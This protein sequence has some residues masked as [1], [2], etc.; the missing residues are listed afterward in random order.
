MRDALVTRDG[1]AAVKRRTD[2][3]NEEVRHRS[4]LAEAAS[5]GIPF[6]L[7]G[8]AGRFADPRERVAILFWDGWP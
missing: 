4:G 5:R 7:T 2:G 8:E 1:N 3:M 6:A